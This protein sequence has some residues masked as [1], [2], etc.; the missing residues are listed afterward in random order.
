[1]KVDREIVGPL[2][3]VDD[4]WRGIGPLP[5]R[6]FCGELEVDGV[7]HGAAKMIGVGAFG[8]V[9]LDGEVFRS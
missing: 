9:V 5:V 1:M 8:R 3:I 6:L 7:K 2:E 4:R